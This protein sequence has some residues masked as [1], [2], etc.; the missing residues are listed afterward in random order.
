MKTKTANSLIY[1]LLTC[2]ALCWLFPFFGLLLES[3]RVETRAQV[4]YLIPRQW[5]LDN[6]KYLFTSF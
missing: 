6:Y 2:M 3:F 5:G 4:G 1:G